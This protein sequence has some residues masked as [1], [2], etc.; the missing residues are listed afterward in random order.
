M[1]E[2]TA[3]AVLG[4]GAWGQALAAVLART[5]HRAWLWSRSADIETVRTARTLVVAVPAQAVRQTVARVGRAFEGHVVIAAKGLEEG[6]AKLLT[7]VVSEEM[8]RSQLTV[9]SG[10]SFAADVAANRPVALALAGVTVDAARQVAALF[11]LPQFRVY[12]TDD[13]IGVQ[14]GGALKNVLAIACGIADGKRLG[15]SARAALVTRAF[16]ELSRL[17]IARGARPETLAGLSGLG[18]LILTATSGQ[19]RN[20]S[21]GLRLGQGLTLEQA[22]E[23]LHGVSEG[24]FTAS[25][26]VKL[27][28]DHG[29]EAP[30]STA[31]LAVIDGRSSAEAE[32]SRLLA[33]PAKSEF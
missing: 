25:A 21:L 29:L 22:L 27:A 14:L 8:P 11:A 2:K 5:G 20:Y 3:V 12:P 26:A 15:D 31:V 19:S 28:Q 24:R 30:I 9:L 32:I 23:G 33:R 13:L 18:D 1:T 7:E 6:S 10:P 16:A 4:A 17:A